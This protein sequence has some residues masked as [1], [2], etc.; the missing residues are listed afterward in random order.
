MKKQERQNIIRQLLVD[1]NI[2][3]QTDFVQLLNAQGVNVTQATISRDI[4]EMQLVKVPSSVGGYRYSMPT[5]KNVNAE[6]KLVQTITES[7][8]SMKIQTNLILLKVI[9]GSGPV[10]SSLL[11]QMNYDEIFGTISDD[12]TVLVICVSEEMANQFSTKIDA[13]V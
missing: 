3:R 1:H 11:S 2:Q 8:I 10:I 9:P 5:Q 7:F 12:N 4:K 13:M 6:R